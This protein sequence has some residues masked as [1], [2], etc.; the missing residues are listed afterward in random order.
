[1]SP[2]PRFRLDRE[3]GSGTTG[4]VW[5]GV[6]TEGFGPY[7]AGQSVAVKYMHAKHETDP[8]A[9]AA[10]LGEAEAGQ[11]VMHPGVVRVLH[12]GRDE[13]GRFLVMTFVPGRNLREVERES[14]LLPEPIV[15]SIARQISAGL[16][17]LHAAGYVHGDIKPENLR[18]DAEGNAVLLDLGFA[19]RAPHPEE[20]IEDDLQERRARSHRGSLSYLAP[21]QAL[22]DAATRSS[23]VFALGVVMYEMATGLHPFAGF[24]SAPS[25]RKLASHHGLSRAHPLLEGASSTTHI[26]R[27]AIEK[28]DA[29]KLLAAIATAR[30]VSPS[31][32]VP[33]LSPFLDRLL[34]DVLQRDP[35]RRPSAGELHGRLEAQESGPWWRAQLE[36]EAGAR[37]GGTGE[38]DAQHLTPLV[39]REREFEELMAAYAADV[40]PPAPSATPGGGAVWISGAPGSGKS[41]L[42]NEFAA[43][44]RT[45]ENPPLYL[46]GRCRELEE[47]RP[48]QPVLRLL[49]RWL[50]LPPGTGL[51]ERERELLAKLVP[52]RV[53]ITLEQ[54]LDPSFEGSSPLALPVALSSWL[55]VLGHRIPLIIFLDDLNFADEGTLAVLALV[56][57]K[58]R[59]SAM[60]LILGL[61]ES[62]PARRA[63]A[64]KTL[65]ERL[66]A[67][68]A[69]REITLAPLDEEAV[70]ALVRQLFHHSAPRLRL[71][72]VLWQRSRGN[73]GLIAEIVRNL[74]A[75]GGARVSED[76]AGLY[77]DISPD[78][79]PLP[80]SLQKAIGESFKQLPAGDRSWLRRLAVVGGRIETEFLLRAFRDAKRADVDAMLLRL[81]RSGWLVPV[82][83]RYR[84]TRPALRETVYRSLSREQRQPLHA[85]AAAA[86]RPAEGEH[87]S[88]EEA[89]QLAFH[90]RAAREHDALVHVLPDLLARLLRGGQPQRVHA[91]SLWGLEAIDALPK[92]QELDRLR[93]SLL[94]AAVDAADRLGF[95]KGQRELL[96]RLTDLDFDPAIDPE[97]VG[98]VYLLHGRYAVSTGQYG[99]ARGMLR[100]AV[101]MFER[102]GKKLEASESVRRLSLVQGHV[103]EL[104]DA[105]KLA[106][107]AIQTSQHD[108]QRALAHLALGTVDILEDHIEPALENS[109]RALHLLRGAPNFH[110]PGAYA[111]AYMLRARVYRAS[112]SPARALAS[113]SRAVELARIA[114]ERRLEAEATARLGGML[115]D[116]D[117]AD[118]AEA[119]LREALRLSEEIEDRRGQALARLFLGVLLWEANDPEAAPMLARTS[120]LAVE[121]GLN[122]V[123][124]VSASLQARILRERGD[125]QRALEASS[126]SMDLL[127]QYGAEL[128]D[129]IVITG[130]HALILDSQGQRAEG[131]ALERKLTERMRRENARIK[132]PLLRLR[133]SRASTRLLEAVLS[134]DGPVYPRLREAE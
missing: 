116:V 14:G 38:P 129:R 45:R 119:R 11:A 100:N 105:R 115:L 74:I 83:G 46:Y 68:V 84:F 5:H 132:S 75:R 106:R 133:Q 123:E 4:Q 9:R 103:G 52:P 7:P 93:V 53:A 82:G 19:R 121:M 33:Q 6:L 67:H 40:Q 35:F 26:A 80:G 86:L 17:A 117:R 113:A 78:D 50:R 90:L 89:F 65:R 99:L 72:T 56:A 112:G 102:S 3:L 71:A 118:E 60:L 54:A 22:G 51:K 48:C 76:G 63:D 114:G 2:A 41:R 61:R 134:P 20:G 1:V 27:A 104:E 43:R 8:E 96:D 49:E 79:L 28:P 94:E 69:V 111:A 24:A 37:R 95:R 16:A 130:T 127:S 108:A 29:D 122:R 34:Q 101:E 81:V 125:I 107:Q 87:S 85:A 18:L 15:R 13:K 62:V 91:L 66:A 120:E 88:L 10:F 42:V 58:L 70:L 131:Q 31:R 110:L 36:F 73:P 32:F 128:G 64:L 126:R 25:D 77:L 12:S 47:D 97:I 39:G 92:S 57:E 21:E 30:F 98:R 109:D 55:A 23:D 124:A 44:A 59:G